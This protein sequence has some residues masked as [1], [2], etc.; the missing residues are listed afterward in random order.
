MPRIKLRD[1]FSDVRIKRSLII[2]DSALSLVT[3][4]DRARPEAN[5]GSIHVRR[6]CDD[7]TT[8]SITS[9]GEINSEIFLRQKITLLN[10]TFSVIYDKQRLKTAT[11]ARVYSSL[12]LYASRGFT[13]PLMCGRY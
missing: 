3:I 13:D 12:S 4:V 2:V 7:A 6:A 11:H 1:L 8:K 5:H 10:L 9:F